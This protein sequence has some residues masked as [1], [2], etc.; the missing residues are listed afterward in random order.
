[1]LGRDAEHSASSGGR[2]VER[3]D[4]TWLRQPGVVLDEE[5]V[6]HQPD[7]FARREVLAGRLVRQLCEPPD[8]VFEHPAHV[9]VADDVRVQVDVR[10]LLGDEIQK[11]GLGQPRDLRGEIEVL[12]DVPD[13]S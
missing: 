9:G 2:V 12:E 13:R 5:E 1:V 11:A 6:D 7:H 3:P 4:H 8:Q 10:E